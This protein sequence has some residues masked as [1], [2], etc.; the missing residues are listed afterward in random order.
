MLT[1]AK[2]FDAETERYVINRSII[3]K[4]ALPVG[5]RYDD[6]LF[7]QYFADYC[8]VARRY[9]PKR[10]FEIGVRFGYTAIAFMLALQS[11]P[12]APEAEY[13]GIDD[14]SYHFASCARA[15]L[16]F[17]TVLPNHFMSAIKHNSFNGLPEGIGTFDLIHVDGNHTAVGVMND[18]NLVWRIL[19]PGGV[20][21]IDDAA[22]F[23]DRG[24]PGEI[25]TAAMEF[26]SRFEN[27]PE[28]VEW[29]YQP[30]QRG[31]LIVKRCA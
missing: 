11:L 20:I 7:Q 3:D 5:D 28:Q 9:Q 16:N 2:L 18:L 24:Q 15:N 23:D 26:L 22:P 25:Y 17:A 27:S 8:G 13:M 21:I 4:V 6:E 1:E 12:D 10:I 19:N 29:Q 14:E 30:N 31:H